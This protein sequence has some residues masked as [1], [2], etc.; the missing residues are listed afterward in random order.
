MISINA[1][2]N[3]ESKGPRIED[4]TDSE[5]SR[6]S[7]CG[8]N[9]FMTILGS[10]FTEASGGQ[11]SEGEPK[12][13]NAVG[14]MV[15][16]QG[17][18]ELGL[19]I[20][21]RLSES[22]LNI[23]QDKLNQLGLTILQDQITELSM[24]VQQDSTNLALAMLQ[25]YT[26]ESGVIVLQ[27]NTNPGMGGLLNSISSGTAML[28]NRINE[29]G[30][31]PG[32]ETALLAEEF[33]SVFPAGKEANSGLTISSKALPQTGTV[34]AEGQGEIP[35]M[36]G[37]DEYKGVIAELLPK[38]NGEIK[39]TRQLE[40]PSEGANKN[41]VFSWF[42]GDM[43]AQPKYPPTPTG[44]LGAQGLNFS[45]EVGQ[46]SSLIGYGIPIT[47]PLLDYNQKAPDLKSSTGGLELLGGEG[48]GLRA[49]ASEGASGNI[50]SVE[51]STTMTGPLRQQAGANTESSLSNQ[52]G[53]DFSQ[54]EA[55]NLDEV[56]T[57]KS[58]SP[59]FPE[60]LTELT[61]DPSQLNK[62]TMLQQGTGALASQSAFKQIT[63]ALQ[64]RILNQ[65]E[66]NELEV[67]LHP[68]ELG[69]IQISLRWE[70]GQ[71]HLVCQAAEPATG[72]LLQ[73]NLTELKQVLQSAGV[74]CGNIDMSF[75]GQT[76]D[77]PHYSW[78]E[79]NQTDKEEEK[80]SLEISYLRTDK[81]EGHR[82]NLM[83]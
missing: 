83:V 28:N 10:Y 5:L 8:Q 33:Q 68:E 12:P 71:V 31:T 21:D 43:G 22:E 64:E 79:P 41:L 62:Q 58:D 73:N 66:V 7:D 75:G 36:T 50:E 67:Q 81:Y 55:L 23:L 57:S 47:E 59:E 53:F 51:L 45:D 74:S 27:E 37:L 54:F 35:Y 13:K 39:Y 17:T 49:I 48:F 40:G 25:D 46:G 69:K 30:T 78:S 4:K 72:Y 29:P 1:L 16:G 19:T 14:T 52:Q 18:D 38:L 3:P 2:S 76:Q 34:L 15:L 82:V 6:G 61:M 63:S 44:N 32:K 42:K 56:V 20:Q 65:P 24:T 77:A 9:F 70:D 80:S 11:D 60:L 26:S